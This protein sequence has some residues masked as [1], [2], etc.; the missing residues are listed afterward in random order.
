MAQLV[1]NLPSM[2][3]TWV[4]SLR[5]EDPLEKGKT[6]H[7]GLSDFHFH[8]QRVNPSLSR[9]WTSSSH[10]SKHV[11]KVAESTKIWET[12]KKK[13]EQN[14]LRRWFRRETFPLLQGDSCSL[15]KCCFSTANSLE[16]CN[17]DRCLGLWVWTRLW[18]PQ[19]NHLCRIK[20]FLSLCLALL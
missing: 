4:Q 19:D 6:T 16:F 20:Q 2:W 15:Q 17:V 11:L 10:M 3:E 1:K 9:A 5:W 8:F 14:I 12:E 13:W 7:A 18:S